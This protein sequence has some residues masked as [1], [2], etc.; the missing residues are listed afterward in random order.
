MTLLNDLASQDIHLFA[1]GNT[2]HVDAPRGGLSSDLVDTLREF[3]PELLTVL[4]GRDELAGLCCDL[5]VSVEELLQRRVVD[6]VDLNDLRAD[7]L[8]WGVMRLYI[9]SWLAFKKQ[10]PCPLLTFEEVDQWLSDNCVTKGG[11]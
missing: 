10:L 11:R 8:K 6:P 9:V 1:V 5:P 3:K 4:Q 7:K 2:L